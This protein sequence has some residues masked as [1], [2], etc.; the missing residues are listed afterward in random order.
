MNKNTRSYII[1]IFISFS[2][3]L[4]AQTT[5]ILFF[6]DGKLSGNCENTYLI[7]AFE[8]ELM[9][10]KLDSTTLFDLLPLKGK[11]TVDEEKY[12]ARYASTDSEGFN[13]VSYELT[14]RA[15]FPQILIKTKLGS[16]TMDELVVSDDR[17]SFGINLQP[18]PPVKKTDLRVIRKVK[19][20]LKDEASW[21]KEDDRDCSADI[22]NK[23]YSL[24][25]AL[26][27]ASIE[28]E[29]AYNHRSAL[30]QKVRFCINDL[31]PEKV[32][33]HRLRDFNN[34]PETTYTKLM[35]FLDRVE[36]EI[37]EELQQ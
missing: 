13:N 20:L 28:V 37:I 21:H 19:A 3:S 5:C 22:D 10:A 2:S 23:R 33:A 18:T 16:F 1:L 17:I 27:I 26:Q 35:S 31:Y 6:K 34:M 14:T 24:F 32:F 30:L 29:G 9:Q 25:C 36:N 11:F 4:I 7:K 12:D 8:I 15:G